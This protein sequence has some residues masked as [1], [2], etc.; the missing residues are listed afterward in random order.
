MINQSMQHIVYWFVTNSSY[1]L[2]CINIK[3][4]KQ[5]KALEEPTNEVRKL[6]I[7][8]IIW[9]LMVAVLVF[10]LMYKLSQPNT[11][12]QPNSIM[13]QPVGKPQFFEKVQ[14][15]QD[16]SDVQTFD[17]EGDA[18]FFGNS[19]EVDV[20][21]MATTWNWCLRYRNSFLFVFCK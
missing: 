20:V 18:L 5:V 14:E 2:K 21:D 4:S 11:C 10:V 17:E 9:Q 6:I 13:F 12:S 3:F 7:S 15:F 1:K 8:T 16:V 19:A